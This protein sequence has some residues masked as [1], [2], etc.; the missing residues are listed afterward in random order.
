MHAGIRRQ[1]VE[2]LLPTDGDGGAVAP[3]QEFQALRNVTEKLLLQ[4]KKE[5]EFSVSFGLDS[6]LMLTRPGLTGCRQW[7]DSSACRESLQL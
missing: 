5:P 7:A 4:L 6:V 2:F 1:R 3:R